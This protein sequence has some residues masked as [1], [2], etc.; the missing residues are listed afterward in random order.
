MRINALAFHCQENEQIFQPHLWY[1]FFVLELSMKTFYRFM[2]FTCLVQMYRL[3][4]H[5]VYGVLGSFDSVV[6]VCSRMLVG[7]CEGLGI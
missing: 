6:T 5:Y 2:H 1:L 7:P 3:F 4:E